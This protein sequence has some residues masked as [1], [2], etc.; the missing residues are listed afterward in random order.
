MATVG[1][2]NGTR[3]RLFV[4]TSNGST[5]TA[6]G[7]SLDATFNWT[8]SPREITNQDS[9]GYAQYLEGKR[10]FTIDFNALHSTDG[11]NNFDDFYDALVSSS[12]R[13]GVTF[14]FATAT[15][16]DTSWTGSAF[17][18]NLVVASGG[19][20]NNMTFNG[21]LQGTGSVTKG[22]VA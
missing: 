3:G 5:Y 13:G 6:Q 12:Q 11:A 22:T 2:I 4:D 7:Y 16:G 14:K 8:H 15:S 18:T 1:P 21:S 19:P 17:I 20:E 9:G 10:G